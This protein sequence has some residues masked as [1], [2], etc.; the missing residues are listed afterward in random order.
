LRFLPLEVSLKRPE[1]DVPVRLKLVKPGLDRGHGLRAE[2]EDAG[3]GIGGVTFVGD[4]SGSE[5]VPQVLAHRRRRG[6]DR[7][8]QLPC[9]GGIAAEQLDDPPP[10]RVSES[11]EEI[12]DL[13]AR[14]AVHTDN[15]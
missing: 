7:R 12:G 13:Y 5:Q 10:G 14:I 9:P 11:V 6:A 2:P 4:E 15:N 3:P 1:L 8:C